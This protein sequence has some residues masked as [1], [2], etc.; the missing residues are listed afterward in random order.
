MWVCAHDESRVPGPLTREYRA[1]DS[2]F[3]GSDT[4]RVR[5]PSCRAGFH[6]SFSPLWR[7]ACPSALRTTVSP[8]PQPETLDSERAGVRTSVSW[9]AAPPLRAPRPAGRRERARTSPNSTEQCSPLAWERGESKRRQWNCLA[10]TGS[11]RSQSAF[12]IRATPAPSG[13][14]SPLVAPTLCLVPGLQ[15]SGFS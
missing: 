11:Y 1:P 8:R 4:D 9:D 15:D 14:S 10:L 3:A 7:W 13:A 2:R 6:R 12:Q 5:G